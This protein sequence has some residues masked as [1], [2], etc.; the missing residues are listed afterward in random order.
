MNI[1]DAMLCRAVSAFC[2]FAVERKGLT[3][4]HCYRL[5]DVEARR[6]RGKGPP[7]KGEWTIAL[8]HECRGSAIQCG[9]LKIANGLHTDMTL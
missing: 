2:P 8:R 5:K 9:R 6:K 3:P 1:A 4:C 7:K